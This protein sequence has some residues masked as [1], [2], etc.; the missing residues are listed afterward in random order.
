MRPYS[1]LPTTSDESNPLGE[2]L[3]ANEDDLSPLTTTRELPA[4]TNNVADAPSPQRTVT[5]VQ[6]DALVV[7]SSFA[8]AGEAVFGW[9]RVLFVVSGI[10]LP[11]SRAERE[12]R[13]AARFLLSSVGSIDPDPAKEAS[14]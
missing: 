7:V 5:E 9:R 3:L 12:L 10:I 4:A 1:H 13:E 14:S 8:S 6:H 2:L 11:P